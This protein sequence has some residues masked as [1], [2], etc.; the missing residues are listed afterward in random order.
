MTIG[1]K[2]TT[3]RIGLDDTDHPESGCTTETLDKLL[4]LLTSTFDLTIQERRLVRL[5]PFAERRTRGSGALGALIAS[6]ESA[7]EPII[8]KCR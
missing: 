8:E 3:I 1:H 6:N 2:S 5:W 7:V 4:R